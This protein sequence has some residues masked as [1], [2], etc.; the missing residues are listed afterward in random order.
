MTALGWMPTRV[1][2]R[3]EEDGQHPGQGHP[4]VGDTNENFTGRNKGPGHQDGGGLA[5][6]GGGEVGGILGEGELASLARVRLA[7]DR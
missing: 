6:L 2:L 7:Q 1:F 4:G 3:R 5:L